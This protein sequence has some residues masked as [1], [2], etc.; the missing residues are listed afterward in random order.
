MAIITML[1]PWALSAQT[2]VH[3]Y[4][5]SDSG[6]TNVA[7]SIGGSAWDGMIMTGGTNALP[8]PGGSI[9][10][11]SQLILTAASQD[12][13]QLP[14]GILSNYTA[15]TIDTWV[16]LGTLPGNCFLWGFGDSDLSVSPPVGDYYIFCQPLNGRIAITAANPGYTGEQNCGNAG[17]FYNSSGNPIHVT[18]VFDPPAGYEALYT[19]GVLAA[20]N[21]GVTVQ[22][23]QISNVV[24]Y[25]GRSLY[26]ADGYYDSSWD[27]FRIWNGALNPLQVA[28]CDVNGPDNTNDDN[29]GTV[30]S[31]Q[32]SISQYQMQQGSHQAATVMAQV[33]AVP[34]PVNISRLASY[35][36]S[37]TNILTVSNDVISAVGQGQASII[38]S[39]GGLSSTQT[40][41]AVSTPPVLMHRY[42]FA[43]DTSDSV[44]GAAWAGTLNGNASVSGG[45]LL[46]PNITST[47]P[48]TNYLQL[49]AGILTNSTDG[50][51]TNFNDPAVTI[52]AWTTLAPS[53]W[54]WAN[55]FDFGVQDS[56]GQDAYSISTCVHAGNPANN[57]IAAI[58]DSDNAN[59]HRQQLAIPQVL[60]G[61]TNMHVAV[62][63]N[64]PAGYLAIYTNGV[65]MG[66]NTSV[67]ISMAGVQGIR[68]LIGAD[69][70]PDPGLNGSVDEF[71]VWNGA[72]SSQEIAL[73]DAAGPNSIPATVT[74]GPGTLLSLTLQAPSTLE[75][76]E[77]A[78][79]RLLA[80]YTSLTN[81]DILGNSIFPVAG[82]TA[83]SS[84][85]NVVWLDSNNVLHSKYPGVATITVVYQGT[86]NAATITVTEPPAPP[87]LVHRY[88]FGDA[89]G[90]TSVA[91]SVGGPAWNGTVM[92]DGTNAVPTD[93]AFTNG[94][95]W[96]N[97]AISNYV[98]LPSGILSNYSAVTIEGWVTAQTLPA[99]CMYYAFGRTEPTN[100]LG[101][102]YIF[103]SLVRGYTAITDG[104][105]SS[106]QGT[107]GGASLGVNTPI[108]FVAVYDPPGGYIAL[109]T[110]G[111][112]QS[113]NTSVTIPLS[114]V[115]PVEAFIGRSLYLGDP[116]AS[117]A[118]DEFR[119][120]NGVMSPADIA[121][122]QAL[123][124]NQVLT[125]NATI[126]A[127]SSGGNLALSWPAAASGF[128]LQSRASLTSG[129]WTTVSPA[130]TLA[131]NQW[132]VTV[133]KTSGT[134]FFRLVR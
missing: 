26:W 97:A 29:Y 19:N 33:S 52:E 80:N 67:T 100:G 114:A 89:N 69:N 50:I 24:N 77:T 23:N 49:P 112:L 8:G 65:L 132:Q 13:V 55:L 59:G 35:T 10:T 92:S 63:F 119:I 62:V 105:Y 76:P 9:F 82:L 61:N 15:V 75:A 51:G 30:T 129:S 128:T 1:M 4:S 73:S 83:T 12:Y 125:T 39:Y 58:S 90:S 41:T 44:G 109:Y 110:N 56:A 37:N 118:P 70:W 40:I 27:E 68:N 18:A 113:M 86:T 42:S 85:T 130:A 93:G 34:Y 38:A 120:Y 48:A 133:P 14:Q 87:S 57:T 121:A 117:I 47:A 106:E 20:E 107:P 46:I 6:P 127:T 45:Q 5:F 84:D 16:T 74:N 115:S 71:R 95:L 131:G 36:S 104:T 91:D 53:Q 78:Q 134:Q 32:L 43:A 94:V 98:R 79:L 122:S 54:T 108:H 28:A 22:L 96:L 66:K 31:L 81:W 64:P 7:D 2:L 124:P 60:D 11:G 102:D 116:Y 126:T 103:G 21:D 3:E 99:N 123:G 17:S 88:S 101:Y 72:L 111:V 25:L